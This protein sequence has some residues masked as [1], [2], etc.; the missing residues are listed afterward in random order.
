VICLDN[1]Q[2]EERIIFLQNRQ[3]VIVKDK[4]TY[5]KI[6]GVKRL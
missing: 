2:E 1:S 3:S 4:L 5:Q 6:I